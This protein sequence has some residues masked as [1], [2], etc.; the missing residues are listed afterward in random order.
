MRFVESGR[1]CPHWD[2][3]KIGATVMCDNT[4]T[5]AFLENQGG[6]GSF[7]SFQVSDLVTYIYLWAKRRGIILVPSYL[8]VRF[9]QEL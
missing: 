6:G 3:E 1:S 8:D 9:G 2:V 4:S 5:V 7:K